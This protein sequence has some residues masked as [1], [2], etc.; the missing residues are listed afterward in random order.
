MKNVTKFL[1]G[2]VA[3]FTISNNVF[4][5]E[6]DLKTA[7]I[8]QAISANIELALNQ[9]AQ[10]NIVKTAKLHADQMNFKQNVEQFLILAKYNEETKSINPQVVSE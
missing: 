7:E 6:T 5:S 10:P 1:I 8:K 2:A 9:I 3:T 4:A